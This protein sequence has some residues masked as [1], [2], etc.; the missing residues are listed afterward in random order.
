[1][2]C[3]AAGWLAA[4]TITA[5]PIMKRPAPGR[6]E[7]PRII[8]ASHSLVRVEHIPPGARRRPEGGEIMIAPADIGPGAWPF[9]KLK[10]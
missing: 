6:A 7:N 9:M 8:R 3:A 1:M 5:A 10:R 2:P 4:R